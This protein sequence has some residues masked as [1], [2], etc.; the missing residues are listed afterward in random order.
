MCRVQSVMLCISGTKKIWLFSMHYNLL[1]SLQHGSFAFH[2]MACIHAF[3]AISEVILGFSEGWVG[4]VAA[5]QEVQGQAKCPKWRVVK[6]LWCSRL[7]L[8]RR[9]ILFMVRE[10]WN[11]LPWEVESPLET[12]KT[13]FDVFLCALVILLCQGVQA[14]WSPEATSSPYHPIILW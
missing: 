10:H 2:A 6:K 12:L 9:R 11:R 5:L 13:C 8:S 14:R 1:R 3:W 7:C 4:A